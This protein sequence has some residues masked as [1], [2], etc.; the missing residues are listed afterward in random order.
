MDLFKDTLRG[1]D[2]I[3]RTDIKRPK[4]VL[5][6]GP[7]G[8]LKSSF[9]YSL[10]TKYLDGTDEFGMYTTLEETVSSHL[11][12][13][14]SLGIKL[15][16]NMQITD[17]TDLRQESE[18]V[19]YT[20]FLERMIKHYKKVKGEKFSVF[21]LD[22]LGALY[23]LMEGNKDMRKKMYHFFQVLRDLNLYSFII[24]ERSLDSESQL[25]GNEGFLADGI[26]FLGLKRKQGRLSRFIQIEKMRACNHSMEMHAV[27]VGEQGI[28]ILGPI[29]MD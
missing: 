15:S 8:S 18:D 17:F 16:M 26:I 21:A 9:I 4:V 24:M 12:N 11:T 29:F 20:L 13:M 7:P 19:D 5:V 1:L 28:S 27:E 2:K 10:I 14:E 25:L 3:F 23:S 6:T 22:S